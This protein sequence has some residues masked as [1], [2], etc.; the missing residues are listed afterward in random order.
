MIL[1]NCVFQEKEKERRQREN[2][3]RKSARITQKQR[4]KLEQVGSFV[5]KKSVALRVFELMTRGQLLK[6]SLALRC[7]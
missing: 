5:T 1:L 2:E 3:L 6:T 7:R 4:E